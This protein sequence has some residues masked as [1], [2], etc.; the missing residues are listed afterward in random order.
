MIK[1]HDYECLYIKDVNNK[2]L[3]KWSVIIA[4]KYN[5]IHPSPMFDEK[6]QYQKSI[7]MYY[8]IK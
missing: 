8:G 4:N 1:K 2:D 3:Y 5:N 6:E 7:D